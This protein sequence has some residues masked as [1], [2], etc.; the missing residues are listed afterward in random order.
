MW[1]LNRLEFKRSSKGINIGNKGVRVT[2]V[3]PCKDGFVTFIAQGG[4]DPF[5]SSIR[6]LVRWMSDEGMT[7]D[8]FDSIDWAE[9]YNASRLVQDKVDR[10]E[11]VF[12]KFF[13]T[14]TKNELYEEGALKRR[15]LIAPISTTEDIRHNKQL[16]SR[17]FWV[18]MEHSELNESILYPGPFVKLNNNP[19][20]F[21]CRAPLIGEHNFE[22]YETHLGMSKNEIA[23][24]KDAGII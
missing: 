18:N 10:A 24:F 2:V 17:G 15:V 7:D 1:D 12:A 20:L 11:K 19:L 8:W 22:I 6:G 16:Q 23:M 3:W 21:R 5:L 4:V 9:D 13:M 14:K